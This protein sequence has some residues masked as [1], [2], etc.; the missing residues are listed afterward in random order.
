MAPLSSRAL[1]PGSQVISKALRAFSACQKWSATT[2]TPLAVISTL[3]T[4]GIFSAAAESSAFT[5]PP[6]TGLWASA[7]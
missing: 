7:A 3:R 4:P 1:A 2:A 5:L 6:S